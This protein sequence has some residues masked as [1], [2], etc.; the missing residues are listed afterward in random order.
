VEVELR[1]SV[2]VIPKSSFHTLRTNI[3]QKTIQKRK[4]EKIFSSG[5]KGTKQGKFLK[6]YVPEKT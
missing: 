6:R 1:G 4:K 3:K 2:L 5:T